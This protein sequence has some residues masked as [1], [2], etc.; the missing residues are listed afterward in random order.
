MLQNKLR[1][2]KNGATSFDATPRKQDLFLICIE[3]PTDS[4]VETLV[5]QRFLIEAQ[6]RDERLNPNFRILIH[7]LESGQEDLSIRAQG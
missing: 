4:G 7:L 1:V 6:A 2:E 5:F 3:I